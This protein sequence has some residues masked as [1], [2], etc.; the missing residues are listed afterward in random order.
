MLSLLPKMPARSG[1]PVRMS[2]VAV[3]ALA[4]SHSAGASA[5]RFRPQASNAALAP[6]Y[7]AWPVDWVM[8][9][10]RM[11]TLLPA[12]RLSQ[13]YLPAS[14]APATLSVPMNVTPSLEPLVSMNTTGMPAAI[15]ASTDGPSATGSVGASA[16]PPTPWV[17]ASSIWVIWDWTS[18]SSGGDIT[19]T[20]TPYVA[21]I[22][23]APASTAAQN[24]LPPPGPFMFTMSFLPAAAPGS[25]APALGAGDWAI[26]GATTARARAAPPMK[27]ISFL[28][29]LSP[30]NHAT[31]GRRAIDTMV[32]RRLLLRDPIECSVPPS[33]SG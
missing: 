20:S 28:S 3:C 11:A 13:K 21:P 7:R 6:S 4:V 19:V 22:S 1:L 14:A 5:T 27:P 12:A 2:S 16:M 25:A 9:P 26:T 31:S 10:C 32:R 15:A 17:I 24:G 29:T 23:L 18:D 33:A 30:P 8:M